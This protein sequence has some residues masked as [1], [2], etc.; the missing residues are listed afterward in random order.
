M[1]F[2]RIILFFFT[3]FL[4]WDGL[5]PVSS[6]PGFFLDGSSRPRRP[7][8]G[9]TRP[10]EPPD[11]IIASQALSCE[12]DRYLSQ[13]LFRGIMTNPHNLSIDLERT[14]QGKMQIKVF[15]PSY[16]SACIGDQG[17]VPELQFVENDVHV[18]FKMEKTFREYRQCLLDEG[19]INDDGTVKD[20]N[21]VRE[22]VSQDK[23]V[24]FPF[25]DFDSKKNA[26]LFFESPIPNENNGNHPAYFDGVVFSSPID[27]FGS[28]PTVFDDK[29]LRLHTSPESVASQ[30]AYQACLSQNY[31]VISSAL[32]NL[33]RQSVGNAG[34]LKKILERALARAREN[35]AQE[36]YRQLED[37]NEDL[38]LDNDGNISVSARQARMLTTKYRNLMRDL[39]NI[40]ITPAKDQLL[41]LL[42]RRELATDPENQNYLDEQ[43]ELI[44]SSIE[45][46]RR[47]RHVSVYRALREYGLYEKAKDIEQINLKSKYYPQLADG[48]N[49]D[50][51][52]RSIEREFRR[53]ERIFKDWQRR[54]QAGTGDESV[55]RDQER[56]VRRM[57]R[58]IQRN[59]MEF[60]RNEMKMAQ[61]YCGRN[62]FGMPKNPS[63]CQRFMMNQ[64][65][66]GN[67]FSRFRARSMERAS[68][69]H[70]RL[71]QYRDLYEA[72]RER[73]FNDW[74]GSGDYGFYDNMGPSQYHSQY[75]LGSQFMMNGHSGTMYQSPGM[76]MHQ[77]PG[78]MYQS[79]GMMMHQNPAM[80]YQSP[81]MMMH[82][83]PGM[84]YQS[85]GMMMH[86]NPAM[87]YQSP[88]M[89]NSPMF[90]PMP[91]QQPSMLQYR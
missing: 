81:G 47:P 36:I 73:E 57:E 91:L 16:Y 69:E 8:R 33:D 53:S 32:A 26:N 67:R 90:T 51:I 55:V 66:R 76:M 85:P 23:I 46:A 52:E 15:V 2:K 88:G 27:C 58:S 11:P 37:I 59:S 60:Q 54:Y 7:G 41:E 86:Q 70:N 22:K 18:K 84:M 68:T 80:M 12:T 39:D 65:Q 9:P 25:N 14:S 29:P 78:M 35:K 83:N 13:N 89:V 64:Q 82:Q 72:S 79:P 42:E 24:K 6:F 28:E 75:N 34:E 71:Q 21:K 1:N 3:L 62:L 61:R 87:M 74:M 56:R 44:A 63:G 48:K 19:Y 31:E 10:V 49:E 17:I 4:C 43:I 38:A 20:E 77:N 5:V 40:L 30:D 45:D 50:R